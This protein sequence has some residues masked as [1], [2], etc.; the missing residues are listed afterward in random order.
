MALKDWNELPYEEDFLEENPFEEFEEEDKNITR[1]EL[2]EILDVPWDDKLKED[3]YLD[4]SYKW[5]WPKAAEEIADHFNFD[6]KWITIDLSDNCIMGEWAYEFAWKHFG[7]WATLNLRN[8]T[9]FWVFAVGLIFGFYFSEGSTLN[10]E[11]NDIDDFSLEEYYEAYNYSCIVL[12]KWAK[13]DLSNNYIWDKWAK[14]LMETTTLKDWSILNLS[15]N[16]RIS[17]EMKKELK[18]WEKTYHDAWINCEVII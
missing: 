16:N 7:E 4:F 1:W 2:K 11:N 6:I 9:I 10:L 12:P 5:L 13:L 15:R 3:Q 8:N 14:I 17:D 18:K